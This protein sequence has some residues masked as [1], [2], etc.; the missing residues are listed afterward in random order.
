MSYVNG[1]SRK[2]CIDDLKK[3][4]ISNNCLFIGKNNL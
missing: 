1:L 3:L 4:V 2:G